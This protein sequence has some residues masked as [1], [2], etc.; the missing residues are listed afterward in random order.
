MDKHSVL[1]EALQQVLLVL[2]PLLFVQLP[3]HVSRHC[4][5]YSEYCRGLIHALERCLDRELSLLV[6]QYVDGRECSCLCLCRSLRLRD[7]II[8][9][10]TIAQTDDAADGPFEQLDLLQLADTAG[11]LDGGQLH[12]HVAVRLIDLHVHHRTVVHLVLQVV[13]P[14]VPSY[15]IAQVVLG[16]SNFEWDVRYHQSPH[17]FCVH[18]H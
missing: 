8:T 9:V 10:T 13:L 12:S 11:F 4:V 7:N 18:Q 17:L 14:H 3:G 5:R 1:R 2:A 15:Q 6:F 16:Y